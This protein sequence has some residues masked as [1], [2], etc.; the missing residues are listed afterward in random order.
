MALK[1]RLNK[2]LLLKSFS[3]KIDAVV[4]VMLLI[5]MMMMVE[6]MV[7]KLPKQGSD[8]KHHLARSERT[9]IG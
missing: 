6:V 1:I 9:G 8:H 7:V 4:R 2:T 5:M 3:C